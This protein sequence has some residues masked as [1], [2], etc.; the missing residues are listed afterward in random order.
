[1]IELPF[2]NFAKNE[3]NEDEIELK[4]DGD[5]VMDDDFWSMLF[6]TENVTPKGF[7]SELSQY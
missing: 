3:N 7:M 6:G 2:W 5:I 1:M 4:I